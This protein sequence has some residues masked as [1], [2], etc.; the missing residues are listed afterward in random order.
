MSTER[1]A[2]ERWP[3]S[4]RGLPQELIKDLQAAIERMK[5]LESENRALKAVK[6]AAVHDIKARKES[7][8]LT[9]RL[10]KLAL[11]RQKASK[12]DRLKV[13]QSDSA[14]HLTGA[15]TFQELNLPKEI[16]DAI[17]AD[18]GGQR[19]QLQHTA[20]VH[21]CFDAVFVGIPQNWHLGGQI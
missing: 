18:A 10:Q 8:E 16:L 21:I 12:G 1:I 11:E 15:K 19:R 13:I 9:K 14:S 20:D 3:R 17:F 4:F 5:A 7:N 6:G 2:L